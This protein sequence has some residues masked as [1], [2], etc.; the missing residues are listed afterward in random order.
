MLTWS[1]RLSKTRRKRPVPETWVT[2]EILETF[3][4][5]PA[6]QA[7]VQ[8][9]KSLSV[10]TTGDSIIVGGKGS[11]VV[12]SMSQRSVV[13]TL[14]CGKS[15]VLASALA[16]ERPVLGLSS[17]SVKIFDKATELASFSAHSGAVTALALHPC[18]DVLASVG[19]DKSFVIYDLQT[20][21][22]IK[23]QYTDSGMYLV[24][25]TLR[26]TTDTRRHH[27][28]CI[29]PRRPSLCHWH[30]G[31]LHRALRYQHFRKACKL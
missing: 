31:R 23:Q 13:H 7:I 1:S 27:M 24:L 8:D 2:P 9:P 16:G 15:S 10:D 12:Y 5:K 30:F 3:E 6:S 25:F 21:K 17:G 20:M 18:G 26:G 22:Q 28:C 11:A 19:V 4:P 29:P 14:D